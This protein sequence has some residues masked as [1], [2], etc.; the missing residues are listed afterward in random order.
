LEWISPT[1]F[2]AQQ[3]DLIA[4]KQDG[5]GLWFLGS[6]EYTAWIQGSEKTLFCPGIPGA[7]KTIMAAITIDH[8]LETI[9]CNDIGVAYLYC[10]YKA[11][12]DQTTTN[13][14][15]A[16]LKQLVQGRL[17]AAEPVVRLFHHHSTRR[18]RPSLEEIFSSLQSVLA[19]YSNVYL[20]VDAFDECAD[21]EGTR[22]QLLDKLRSLQSKAD[23]HIMVTSRFIPKIVN[24]FK[25]APT[26][27]VRASKTD[28]EQFVKSRMH[29]LP[30]CVQRDSALQAIVQEKV[31][32]AVDGM[33]VCRYRVEN[34]TSLPLS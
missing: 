15:S 27:E 7:G 19:S 10:N 12:I 25:S 5:T 21:K 23:L 30:N 8:L 16:I 13:I 2:P 33:L 34:T 24:E 4:R 14:L 29:L 32:E 6:T 3:S 31:V 9:Q 26:L 22:S 11:Q 20:V 1:D 17:S 28:V 18:T